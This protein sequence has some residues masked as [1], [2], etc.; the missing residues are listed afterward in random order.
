MDMCLYN[1]QEKVAYT[2]SSYILMLLSRF[3]KEET[4]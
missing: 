3:M 1:E 4:G 2:L